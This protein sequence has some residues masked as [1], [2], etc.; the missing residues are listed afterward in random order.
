MY[1][2][3][4][5]IS[6]LVSGVI[7]LFMW[8]KRTLKGARML[9]VLMLELTIWVGAYRMMG[10]SPVLDTQVFWLNIT[11]FGELTVP[12]TFLQP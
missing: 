10:S 11:Y 4:L 6:A 9:A 8:T 7:T 1:T 12:I 5:T 2:M 3:L